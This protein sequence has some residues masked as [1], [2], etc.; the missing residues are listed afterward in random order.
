M[1]IFLFEDDI[2]KIDG[3]DSF[4]MAGL[5]SLV[6]LI[7]SFTLLLPRWW[8]FIISDLFAVLICGINITVAMDYNPNEK[9]KAALQK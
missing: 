2:E 5:C 3:F 7:P 8:G 4:F 1:D 9:E 6:Y